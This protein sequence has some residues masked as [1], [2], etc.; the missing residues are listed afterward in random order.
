MNPQSLFCLNLACASRGVSNGGNLVLHDSLKDRFRCKTCGKTFA[1]SKGT[2]FY[3][4]RT[5]P[6]IV[7]WVLTLLAFGC[8]PQAIVRA[9]GLDERTVKNW[10]KKAG[11]HCEQV[12]QH[13]VEGQ[14]RDLRHVQADEIRV[15]M[16][17][18]LVVW[19]AMAICV[20]SRL[21]LGGVVS[22][23]RD[24]TLIARLVEKVRACAL[25]APLLLMSDGLSSY[26]GAWQ[27]AFRTPVLTGRAGRPRLL[28]WPSVVIGQ[29][30]KQYERGRVVGVVQ[31]LVQGSVDHLVGLQADENKLNTAYIERLNATFRQRLCCL[32]RRSRCLARQE[33]TLH[34]GMYLLGCVYNLCT[35]HQSLRQ[36]QA[37]GAGKW[38]ERT[39]AMAA[40]IT[41]ECWRVVDLFTYRVP[42]P[43]LV[44]K[45]RR[46][47]PPGSSKKTAQTSAQA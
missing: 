2:L 37:H 44:P 12:H 41:S 29:V 32:V 42:P 35:P 39:P 11:E 17:K 15:K 47:R 43:P 31:R 14:A 21:W 38:Q 40:G 16:Q 33:S 7:I 27:R 25:P 1:S 36:E 46:G 24:R 3:R 30:V 34:A 22:A 10:Q 18:R 4:L 19:V 8:P 20:S 6:Q 5:D 28:A 9:F 45:K 23:R 13:L 26:V